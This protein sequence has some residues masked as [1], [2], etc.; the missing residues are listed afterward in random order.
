[1]F[2]FDET[3]LFHRCGYSQERIKNNKKTYFT[4]RY[5]TLSDGT[6]IPIMHYP[7][8]TDGL[9]KH[10]VLKTY[11]GYIPVENITKFSDIFNKYKYLND[12]TEWIMPYLY[13]EKESDKVLVDN[14]SKVLGK[15]WKSYSNKEEIKTKKRVLVK[16]EY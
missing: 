2:E 12:E 6:T 4:G 15:H 14:L 13:Q 11:L 3:D 5:Y 10:L 1:M 9:T 8:I 7:I 16:N